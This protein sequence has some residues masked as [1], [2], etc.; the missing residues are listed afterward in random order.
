M[1]RAYRNPGAKQTP[2]GFSGGNAWGN[3]RS[4]RGGLGWQA[5]ARVGEQADQAL[6]RVTVERAVL[7]VTEPAAAVRTQHVLRHRVHVLEG[8]AEVGEQAAQR[9]RIVRL[10]GRAHRGASFD[11]RD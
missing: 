5:G 3:T 2:R 7:R 10:E 6:P 8:D 1:G 11:R 9:L 4:V